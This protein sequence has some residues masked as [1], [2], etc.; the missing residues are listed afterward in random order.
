MARLSLLFFNSDR[1]DSR[2][3]DDSKRKSAESLPCQ[4]NVRL[5]VRPF[6]DSD[7]MMTTSQH[8]EVDAETGAMY[9]SS[10]SVVWKSSS[11][12]AVLDVEQEDIT[13]RQ[14]RGSATDSCSSNHAPRRTSEHEIMSSESSDAILSSDCSV[15]SEQ[16]PV[17]HTEE[18]PAQLTSPCT[19]ITHVVQPPGAQNGVVLRSGFVENHDARGSRVTECGELVLDESAGGLSEGSGLGAGLL[20]EIDD[21]L[22]QAHDGRM[23]LL[24]AP[25]VSGSTRRSLDDTSLIDIDTALA[26]VMSGLELLG[27]SRGL[28]LDYGSSMDPASTRQAAVCISS[29]SSSPLG[30]VASPHTPDLVVGLPQVSAGVGSATSPRPLDHAR[31]P[32]PST[33]SGS[34]L[35]TAAEMFANVDR[36]TIKKSAAST[37]SAPPSAEIWTSSPTAHPL[38]VVESPPSVG[39]GTVT[40]LPGWSPLRT[41]GDGVG[42]V[43]TRGSPARSQSCRTDRQSDQTWSTLWLTSSEIQRDRR[44]FVRNVVTPQFSHQPRPLRLTSPAGSRDQH[45]ISFDRADLTADGGPRRDASSSLTQSF[46]ATLPRDSAATGAAKTTPVKVKPPVMKKPARSAEMMRRLSEYQRQVTDLPGSPAS[47]K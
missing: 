44:E 38:R 20:E 31:S 3:D 23:Q 29:S 46:I 15:S 8:D 43:R 40:E 41:F 22:K 34:H 18:D 1:S 9:S 39:A 5:S 12:E 27:R 14:Q 47:P 21:H 10:G 33:T 30:R 19:A 28:S 37:S 25:N 42:G 6:D 16:S 35:T 11:S 2:S 45:S 13:Q 36:S 4:R 26:E 32:P 17:H 7:D 24:G